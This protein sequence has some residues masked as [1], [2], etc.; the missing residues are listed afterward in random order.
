MQK[1]CKSSFPLTSLL[2]IQQ[3]Y[4]AEILQL[5][6]RLIF[7]VH[8]INNCYFNNCISMMQKFCRSFAIFATTLRCRNSE[9][10]LVARKRYM[11]L[12]NTTNLISC[13]LIYHVT[14]N[15]IRDVEFCILTRQVELENKWNSKILHNV[16]YHIA[17]YG[18]FEKTRL[19]PINKVDTIFKIIIIMA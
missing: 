2:I 9:C 8:T 18:M 14:Y 16:S 5:L 1:F 3:L 12:R 13:N 11:A 15:K 6:Q 10:T 17:L 7:H 19:S 4:G